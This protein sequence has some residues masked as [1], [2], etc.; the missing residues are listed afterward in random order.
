MMMQMKRVC[1]FCGNTTV[2]VVDSED[3]EKWQGGE[4]IQNVF[5]DRPA[6]WREVLKTGMCQECQWEFFGNPK[7]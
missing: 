1:P 2:I 5:A 6:E 3:L 4:L 7:L